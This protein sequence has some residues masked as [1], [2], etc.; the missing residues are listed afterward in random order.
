MSSRY[1]YPSKV[2]SGTREDPYMPEQI[3]GRVMLNPVYRAKLFEI[4][5]HALVD[6]GAFQ[7]IDKHQRLTP[8]EAIDRQLKYRDI[9]RKQFNTSWNFEAVSIY[10]QMIG[11]DE[12]VIN[13]QKKK[14]RGTIETAKYAIESTL[15]SA[16]I[17]KQYERDLGRIIYIAQGVTPE[18]YVFDCAVP[19]L[20]YL[21]PGIDYFGIGGFCIIG[22]QRR[23]LLPL[24]KITVDLLLPYLKHANVQRIHTYGICMPEAIT[25]IATKTEA[26]GIDLSTDSSAPELNAVAFGRQYNDVG[27]PTVVLERGTYN[28]IDLA[29]YNIQKYDNWM[30]TL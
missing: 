30:K 8:E 7:D 2:Y 17:Y 10:D 28:K 14:Q 1:F 20:S 12:V 16:Y 22:K 27:K 18:Q 29:H 26:Y 23:L 5:T 9:F 3:I 13:G 11:V 25:Y 15:K 4:P 6:S 21:R 24:F 19:L